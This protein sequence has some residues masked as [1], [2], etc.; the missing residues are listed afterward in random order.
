MKEFIYID[1]EINDYIYNIIHITFPNHKM[2][3]KMCHHSKKDDRY[4]GQY[5]IEFDISNGKIIWAE[6]LVFDLSCKKY[7]ER[8]VSLLAFH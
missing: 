3:F 2:R 4:I 5:V 7:C 8:L 1:K 6:D